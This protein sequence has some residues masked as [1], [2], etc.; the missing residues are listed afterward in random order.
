MYKLYVPTKLHDLLQTQGIESDVLSKRFS[1]I[2]AGNEK[3][4]SIYLFSKRRHIHQ[5]LF[6]ISQER[7]R[8]LSRRGRSE[9][10]TKL[11]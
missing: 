9:G 11:F 10:R 4:K 8:E 7:Y 6:L 5:S 1:F 3:A 2:K